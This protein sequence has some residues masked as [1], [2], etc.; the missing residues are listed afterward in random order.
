MANL[1]SGLQQAETAVMKTLTLQT[2]V[3]CFSCMPAMEHI[4][5]TIIDDNY[6]HEVCEDKYID[7]NINDILILL[8]MAMMTMNTLLGVDCLRKPWE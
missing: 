8:L 5:E 1:A 2:L 6:D 7:D 4:R 3:L